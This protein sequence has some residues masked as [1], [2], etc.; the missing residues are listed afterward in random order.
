MSVKARV[1]YMNN[2]NTFVYPRP[3]SPSHPTRL[4]EME[5]AETTKPRGRQEG[6]KPGGMVRGR[7][8]DKYGIRPSG[9]EGKP[10]SITLSSPI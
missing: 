7:E 5:E 3:L 4:P 8:R 9:A 10:P 2:L 1:V 6:R